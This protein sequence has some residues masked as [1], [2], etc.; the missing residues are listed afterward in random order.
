MMIVEEPKLLATRMSYISARGT[1]DFWDLE[2]DVPQRPNQERREG[3]GFKI[4]NMIC[5]YAIWVSKSN[6]TRLVL[7]FKSI[8]H[9]SICRFVFLKAF[10]LDTLL[11]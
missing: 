8:I 4:A 11:L 10:I 5:L 2:K 6:P 9:L 3:A 1:V 7:V